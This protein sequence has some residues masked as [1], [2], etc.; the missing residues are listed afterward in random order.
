MHVTFPSGPLTLEGELTSPDGAPRGAVICHPH[1]QYGGDMDN[2]VVLAVAGALRD[3]GH[4][5]LRFN[6][7]G[8]GASGGSYGGGVGEVE[9]LRAAVQF[10]VQQTGSRSVTLAGYSFGA[11]VALQVGPSAPQVDRL[12]AVAPPLSFADL[13]PVASWPKDKLFIV[14]DH[15]QYCSVAQL[16]AQ[17]ARVAEPKHHQVIAGAD[18]FFAGYTP[19][20]AAGV[21]SFCTIL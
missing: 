1:P 5:T 20:V 13:E 12:V 17:L 15:D 3:A 16:I 18:H 10:L 14:G 8:V 11:I 4:T 19:A 9:D 7:R 2:P 6:F 21:R